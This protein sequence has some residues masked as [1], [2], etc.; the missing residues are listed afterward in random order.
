LVAIVLMA[1]IGLFA[2]KDTIRWGM[3]VVSGREFVG[4][5]HGSA[6][7]TIQPGD[8]GEQV[9]KALFEAGITASYSATYREILRENAA[10][11]PGQYKLA[12]GMSSGSAVARWSRAALELK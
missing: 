5:G 11:F 1:G 3:D 10:F 8:T 4:E 2:A 7:I 9:A 12:L 6:L